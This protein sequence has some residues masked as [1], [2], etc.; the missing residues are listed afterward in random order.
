MEVRDKDD[1]SLREPLEE[2]QHDRARGVLSSEPVGE[3]NED[4]LEQGLADDLALVLAPLE[5]VM[6]VPV[7]EPAVVVAVVGLGRG[8]LRR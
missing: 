6:Q 1:L 2:V 5:G 4:V 7:I 8:S 3:G